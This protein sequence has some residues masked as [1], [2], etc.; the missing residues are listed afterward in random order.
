VHLAAGLRVVA[1]SGSE[2]NTMRKKRVLFVCIHNSARSVM[3]E[4]FLNQLCGDQY[5][6]QS[7]GIE[8]GTLNPLV[9]E[10][11]QEIGIDVSGHRPQ[12]VFDVIRS[13]Q[14]FTNVITV[15]DETSAE[16]CP[17]FPGITERLH[18]GFPDPSALHGTW[19]EKL[20]ATRVIRDTIKERI[21]Q[22]FCPAK[23]L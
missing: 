12:A 14:L 10:V 13:G 3:A 19:E 17:I 5:E 21:A 15:C 8:P 2:G 6:A 11:M 18:W 22:E 7:A 1:K 20:A 23:C 16:R 9:K 4:A